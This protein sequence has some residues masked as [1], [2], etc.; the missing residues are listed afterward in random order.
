[1]SVELAVQLVVREL[2]LRT[3]RARLDHLDADVTGSVAQQMLE[4]LSARRFSEGGAGE[5]VLDPGGAQVE[6]EEGM[7]LVPRPGRVR[8]PV[9]AVDQGEQR[10]ELPEQG[11]PSV[12]QRRPSGVPGHVVGRLLPWPGPV[13]LRARLIASGPQDRACRLEPRLVGDP[14]EVTPRA[15]AWERLVRRA[16]LGRPTR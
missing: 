8:L 15:R 14:R 7:Q 4:V 6:G 12:G 3:R 11:G 9:G 1:M 13:L 2:S 5:Q 16:C 10:R